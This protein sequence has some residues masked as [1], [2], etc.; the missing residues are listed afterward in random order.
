MTARRLRKKPSTTA[1]KSSLTT[2]VAQEA[3]V[4]ILVRGLPAAGSTASD[5][6]P[7]RALIREGA[8]RRISESFVIALGFRI[9]EQLVR[10]HRSRLDCVHRNVDPNHVLVA[11]SGTVR[12]A[13]VRFERSGIARFARR[14][15]KRNGHPSYRAPEQRGSRRVDARADLFGLGI[16]LVDLLNNAPLTKDAPLDI[17]RLRHRVVELCDRRG[18]SRPLTSLLL[19]LTAKDRDQRP[20][21]AAQTLELFAALL[22]RA[23]RPDQALPDPADHAEFL[24]ANSLV[25]SVYDAAIYTDDEEDTS[26]EIA[27]APT[28]QGRLTSELHDS[29][30]FVEAALIECE[31]LPFVE[32]ISLDPPDPDREPATD[33]QPVPT[34]ETPIL[35]TK[36]KKPG[37]V[38]VKASLQAINAPVV[39]DE[40]TQLAESPAED[41]DELTAR[42]SK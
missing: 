4:D 31:S 14:L 11:P 8:L 21:S 1:E 27:N 30:P 34:P 22:L 33:V 3:S 36:V 15:K 23:Y 13:G 40:D 10:V 7:L 41:A 26:T 35:L 29:L 18:V 5:V 6:R 25:V 38:P 9:A 42:N 2:L 24:A 28:R 37:L 20:T 17:E 19:R 16:V 12:L 39:E 32:A